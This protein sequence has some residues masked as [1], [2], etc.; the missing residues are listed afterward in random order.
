[1]QYAVLGIFFGIP[2]K[3]YVNKGGEGTSFPKLKYPKKAEKDENPVKAAKVLPFVQR[4]C[5]LL[6]DIPTFWVMNAS[7]LLC[8][9]HFWK[10]PW[11]DFWRHLLKNSWRHT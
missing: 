1:M 7:P 11:Q 5:Q 4:I 9:K 10:N 3:I 2:Q 6:W 8:V